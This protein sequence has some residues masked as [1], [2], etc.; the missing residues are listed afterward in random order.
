MRFS[1]IIRFVYENYSQNNSDE[2]LKIALCTHL[3]H[4]Y[5]IILFYCR[6]ESG[7]I[8]SSTPRKT[9]EIPFRYL[10]VLIKSSLSE[11]RQTSYAPVSA[12]I[13][14][15]DD[16]YS[17]LYGTKTWI[18]TLTAPGKSNQIIDWTVTN[19][20]HCKQSKVNVYVWV[21]AV[22]CLCI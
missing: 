15:F 18:C 8:S 22:V 19:A 16:G 13:A 12:P 14:Y 9:T 1:A 3:C 10:F 17:I 21:F 5:F 2:H 4:L 20:R 6:V 11:W 7:E